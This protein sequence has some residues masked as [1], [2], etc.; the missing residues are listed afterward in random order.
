MFRNIW[1]LGLEAEHITQFQFPYTHRP[2]K[3]PLTGLASGTF[4]VKNTSQHT[5][6]AKESFKGHW[7]SANAAAR[8]LVPIFYIVEQQR[9]FVRTG[10][11]RR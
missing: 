11:G 2:I 3:P 9:V 8:R 1:K 5:T 4:F 6:A 7:K 10:G